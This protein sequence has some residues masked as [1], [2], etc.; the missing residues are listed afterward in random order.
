MQVVVQGL[1]LAQEL[2][3]EDDVPGAGP[4]ADRP[5]VADRDGGLDHHDRVRVDLHD[6]IDHGLHRGR[7]EEVLLAVVVRGRRDDHEVCVRV[8]AFPVQ[9]GGQVQLLLREVPL[10]VLVLD[11]A[12]PLVDLLDLLRNDVDRGDMMVLAQQR[13]ERQA[14][15]TR[16][17]DRNPQRIKISHMHPQ[18]LAVAVPNT[19]F[20]SNNGPTLGSSKNSDLVLAV[21]NCL[22]IKTR[23]LNHYRHAMR[24]AIGNKPAAMKFNFTV[25]DVVG[26]LGFLDFLGLVLAR[27]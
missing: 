19:V 22:T 11:R 23:K 8:R 13:R 18:S 4:L 20:Y 14:H 26:L 25:A 15:V 2:R 24:R 27:C 7:V 5:G 12:D 6:Q 1:A 10:D 3:A 9:R 16:A 17:G 21:Q